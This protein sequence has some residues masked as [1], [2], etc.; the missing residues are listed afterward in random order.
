M[1]NSIAEFEINGKKYRARPLNARAQ[2]HIV[3]R[4][5]PVLSSLKDMFAVATLAPEAREN[6]DQASALFEASGPFLEAINKMSD[7]DTDYI[8]DRC[9]EVTMRVGPDGSAQAMW[10]AA[11]RRPMFD[12]LTMI[13]MLSIVWNVLQGSASLMGFSSGLLSPSQAA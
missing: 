9:L 6:D 3:R 13:E 2:F 7:E 11:A 4:L 5:A 10:N 1:D 8:I 12:D